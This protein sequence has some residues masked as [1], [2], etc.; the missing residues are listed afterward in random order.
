MRLLIDGKRSFK[1]EATFDSTTAAR[2][3]FEAIRQLDTHGHFTEVWFGSL[4]SGAK[5]IKSIL[6]HLA[7]KAK[8]GTAPLINRVFI[9]SDDAVEVASI[10]ASLA[11]AGIE[12]TKVISGQE[13]FVRD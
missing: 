2:T 3:S 10:K 7:N 5:G 11:D 4:V 9:V 12:N 13:Y 8:D 6:K 1:E